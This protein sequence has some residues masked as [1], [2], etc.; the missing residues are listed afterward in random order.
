VLGLGNETVR[1]NGH[2]LKALVEAVT[3]EW[4]R[5]RNRVPEVGRYLVE[6]DVEERD[7]SKIYIPLTTAQ[8]SISERTYEIGPRKSIGATDPEIF[9]QFLIESVSLSLVGGLVG[10]ALGAAPASSV[11]HA[12]GRAA[13]RGSS[14]DGTASPSPGLGTRG[15]RRRHN[16]SRY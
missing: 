3:P 5:I 7:N 4:G 6:S 16:V 2:T 10:A 14:P 9:G 11:P 13:P 1:M 12:G 15:S 8:I